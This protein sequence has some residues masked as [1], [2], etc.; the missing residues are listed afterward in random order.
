MFKLLYTSS[1]DNNNFGVSKVISSLNETLRKKNIK[2][3]VITLSTFKKTLS[4]S[5][6]LRHTNHT[7][8]NLTTITKSNNY[9]SFHY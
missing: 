2:S 3:E 7:N 8:L 4:S 9:N 1:E 5:L 6:Q